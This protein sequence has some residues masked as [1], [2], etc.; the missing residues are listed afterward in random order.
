MIS[1][2]TQ[3]T[4][5]QVIRDNGALDVVDVWSTLQGEGPFAG[6]PAVFVRLA[7]CNLK[8]PACD[9]DYTT[10]REIYTPSELIEIVHSF[11]PATRPKFR[12]L[13]LAVITGGE[14]FRQSC[15]PFVRALLIAGFRVQ[16]ETNGTLYDPSM[17]DWWNSVTVVCSPKSGTVNPKLVKHISVMKYVLRDGEVDELDGLPTSALM[18]GVR[19][20]RHPHLQFGRDIYLQPCDE[21]DEVANKRNTEATIRSCQEFGYTF[22]LQVHKVLG[23]A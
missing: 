17:E 22:C 23:L 16:F 5:K 15:G 19:P 11:G 20:F 4:E 18:N 7:G 3:P 9:T 21:Q 1:L 12:G 2:N 6:V 14:P 13:G 10:N 8:C